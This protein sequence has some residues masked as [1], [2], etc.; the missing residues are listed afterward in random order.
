MKKSILFIISF[1]ILI[2]SAFALS[3][4]PEA[5][6]AGDTSSVILIFVLSTLIVL[7][8]SFLYFLYYLNI[9][10]SVMY[11][12]QD[13]KE[14]NPLFDFV[15]A[16]PIEREHEIMTDHNYDG[17]R[18]LDNNLP[19]W[20]LYMFYATIVFAVVYFFYYQTS[21]YGDTQIQE[22]EKSIIVA[23]EEMKLHASKVDENSAT[24]LTDAAAIAEGKIVFMDNCAACHGKLGEGGVGPNFTDEYWLHGGDV[25]SIFKTIKFGV[26]E[27]GMIPWQSQ[28]SP[29]QIQQ[30]AS[31]ILTLKGTNPPNAKAPQGE[32]V[33]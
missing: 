19:T 31:Y 1:L 22:Y 3:V 8:L 25:K 33:K 9:A 27:K 29:P 4:A 7:L 14:V 16:V 13:G 26:P 6:A 2:H 11:S 15:D 18:E 28:I 30:V 17:I 23:N 20:W 24:Q 12:K 32:L 5:P 10:L 21:G